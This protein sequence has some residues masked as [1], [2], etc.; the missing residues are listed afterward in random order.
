MSVFMKTRSKCKLSV[1][2]ELLPKNL[3][4]AIDYAEKET[5][6]YNKFVFTVCLAYGSRER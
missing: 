4:D 3:N 5:K 6:D 1:E 2:R